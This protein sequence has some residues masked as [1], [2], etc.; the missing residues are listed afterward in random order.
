MTKRRGIGWQVKEAL[1]DKDVVLRA[2][3]K[4]TRE[5]LSKFG[6]Y[7]RTTAK[8]SIKKT[9]FASK[10]ERGQE[11]IDFSRKTSTPGSP[12]Y[13]QTGK[14]KKGIFFSFDRQT[15]SVVTGPARFPSGKGTAPAVLE[16]GGSVGSRRNMRRTVRHVGDGGEIE[17]GGWF[18]ATTKI[19][20]EG[21][22]VTYAKLRT[23]AQADRANRLNAKLYGPLILN[24]K[25][26]AAR[27]YM[28]PALQKE[29][30]KLPAMW[31]NSVKP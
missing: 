3:D 25:A 31:A 19:N 4:A 21:T 5:V 2:V 8:Q 1:F 13:S 17:I 10:K 24:P 14:L 9:P 6:A 29:L 20:R 16:Y 12:P 23:Q 28:Q 7:V 27:H 22:Q 11:R 30:P 26:V 15:K 18:C